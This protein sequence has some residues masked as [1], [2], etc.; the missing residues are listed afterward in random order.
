MKNKRNNELAVCGFAAVKAL[1]KIHP[2]SIRRF[3]FTA[4]R[5]AQ[6]G[7]LCRQLAAKK[8]PYNMVESPTELEKLSGSIH[9]QGVTA[10]IDQPVIPA[11][12]V[13]DIAAWIAGKETV[14]VLDRIGNAN[15]LGAIVRSAAFFGVRNLVV[16]LDEAQTSVTTSSYRVAQGGMEYVRLYSVRYLIR[17]LQDTKGRMIR[18][19]TD[20][21]AQSPV[22][23]IRTLTDGKPL[24]IVL[25]N[26]E[27]GISR[28]V[29]AYCD[30]LIVIPPAQLPGTGNSTAG[31][32]PVESLNVAQAASVILYECQKEQ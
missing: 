8:I 4:D 19:G 22:S 14:L 29:K 25:G 5:S 16:P 9:H 21:H 2:D 24:L 26:E 17:L 32:I 13:T 10:M 27:T 3:Y 6:F 15:N 28:E 23:A 30:H 20:V 18:I 31:I 1:E 11:L 7:E 12:T